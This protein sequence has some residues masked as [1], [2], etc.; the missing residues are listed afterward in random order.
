MYLLLTLQT[1]RYRR[2][3]GCVYRPIYNSK[4]YYTNAWEKYQT[5]EEFVW[6]AVD[7][8]RQSHIFKI[9]YAKGAYITEQAIKVL[10]HIRT[11]YFPELEPNRYLS[12]W[13]NGIYDHGEDKY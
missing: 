8:D 11:C 9:Q 2:F 3:K 12:S 6:G 1:R 7:L 13:R 10:K 5:I 4:G